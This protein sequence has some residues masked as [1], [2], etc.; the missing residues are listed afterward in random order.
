MAVA[1]IIR[2]LLSALVAG[3]LVLLGCAGLGGLRRDTSA[4]GEIRPSAPVEYDVLV[5]QLAR[6]QGRMVESAAAYERAVAKDEGSAYLHRKTAEA[7]ALVHRLE[8]AVIH[9]ERA[10]ELDAEDRSLRLFLTQLYRLTRNP[11]GAEGM[12]RDASGDPLDETAASM[13][14]RM[15]VSSGRFPEAL[16]VAEWWAERDPESL[17]ALRALARAYQRSGRGEEAESVLGEAL[18]RD[19]TNLNVYDSLA[20]MLRAKGDF[21]GEIDLYQ[22]VLQRYPQHHATL[23]RLAEAH[24]AAGEIDSAIVVL[25]G[26]ERL[27]PSDLRSITRLAFLE[28]E[29][30]EFVEAATRFER[31]LEVSPERYE[32]AFFLGVV[33]RRIGDDPGAIE[34]FDRIPIDHQHYVEARTQ[35]AVILEQ[36]GDF[37]GALAEVEAAIAVSP[38]GSLAM[39]RASL[40]AEVGE[41]DAAVDLLEGM[42]TGAA[43]DDEIL[44]SLGVIHSEADRVDAAILYMQRAVENNPDNASALNFVGYTWAESGIR[45]DEAEVMILRAVELRPDDGYIA[46]SLGWVYYMRAQPL[47]ESG[48]FSEAQGYIE[49]ALHE[50][51]R[52]ESLTGGDPVVSEHLGDTYLLL[53]EKSLALEQFEEAVRLEPRLGEQPN[54]FNKI[55][56][57]QRELR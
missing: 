49:R 35:V 31:V 16:E 51:K 30:R 20:R 12:L 4:G 55:D 9:A 38:D 15:Y 6:N 40:L 44:Y 2:I 50:L 45:L 47:V 42:L 17:P 28:Y 46:D 19:P 57:L 13:L 37:E 39:Y 52:A 41:F 43:E 5:A 24:L 34:A 53:N 11:A 8:D 25:E 22:D 36:R 27:Y 33:R 18:E 14:F 1:P 3:Q 29:K 54:L 32:L 56:G 10:H 21:V 7:L 23:I 48:R 26:I